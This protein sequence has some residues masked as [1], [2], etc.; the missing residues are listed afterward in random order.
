MLS[1]VCPFVLAHS[2][3]KYAQ[4]QT[5]PFTASDLSRTCHHC[6]RF[7]GGIPE[8]LVFDQDS[9]VSVS[10]NSGDIIHTFE[11][12]KLCQECK[13]RVYLCRA[14]DP[15]SKG[16]IGLTFTR[17]PVVASTIIYILL[18]IIGFFYYYN[19]DNYIQFKRDFR[20]IFRTN[21]SLEIRI[22]DYFMFPKVKTNMK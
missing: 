1:A 7:Y 21:E 5:R 3:Q 19:Y 17:F 6:F 4:F 13:F 14:A 20:T 2:R 11:F 9:I 10:E 22:I 8:E 12:E 18:Y 15:E 16:K